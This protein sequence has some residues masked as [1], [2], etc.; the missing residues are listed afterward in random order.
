MEN[1][2]QSLDIENQGP[3]LRFTNSATG[4][5]TAYPLTFTADEWAL[6]VDDVDYASDLA[7]TKFVSD[8]HGTKLHFSYEE[9][10]E[11]VWNVDVPPEE[12]VHALLHKL[13]PLFLQDEPASFLRVR[14]TIARSLHGTELLPFLRWTLALYDGREMQKTIVMQSNDQVM[15]SEKMLSTWLNG[16]EYHRE[17]QKRELL[18]SHN[19]IMP[20]EWSRGVFLTLLVENVKAIMQL[21]ALVELL[22]KKRQ[23]LTI[24]M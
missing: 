17:R 24:Q 23:T 13:R 8:G 12:I 11:P 1:N 2:D 9:G 16:Y 14:S 10:S 20:L 3:S 21:N 19:K 22:L 18:E 6:L 15:N 5:Q 4:K 7:A